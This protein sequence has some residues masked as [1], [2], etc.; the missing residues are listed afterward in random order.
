MIELGKLQELE[1]SRLTKVGAFLITPNGSAREEVLLPSQQVPEDADLGDL[2]EV[3]VY[4]DSEDR[5]IA[6]TTKPKI[7]LGEL[8]VLRVVDIS[9]IGA[10]LDW[11]LQKDLLLPYKEQKYEVRKD[12]EYLVGLYIDKTDRLCATMDISRLLRDDSPY[13][14]NDRVQGIIYKINMEIGAFVAVDNKYNGLIPN[15]ELYGSYKSGDRV[16]V[17]IK[18][19]KEDGKLELSLRKEAHNQMT[20]D[21]Q[22]IFEKLEANGGKLPFNDKSQPEEIS[23]V[24]QMS[25]A[26]FKRAVGRLLKERKIRIT[27]KGI[28]RI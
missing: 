4:K 23:R 25:K 12:Q 14:E 28:E 17:R 21:A 1:I 22:V 19:V 10:F 3:F 2:I 6:T 24:F 27:E 11:G 9:R 18:K 20:D 16:E 7:T 13:K 15:K 26:A 5:T 8:A